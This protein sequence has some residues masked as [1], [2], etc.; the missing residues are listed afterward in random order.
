MHRFSREHLSDDS[1]LDQFHAHCER[2]EETTAELIADLAEILHR[3]LHARLGFGS[4]RS[5]CVRVRHL[6]EDAAA[7]RIQVAR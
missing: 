7:K 3:R 6:S 4:L 2:D 1:L 5:Y